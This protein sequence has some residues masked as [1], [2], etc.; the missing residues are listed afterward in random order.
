MA[1]VGPARFHVLLPETVEAEASALAARLRE[2][3]SEAVTGQLREELEIRAVAASPARGG[4][5]GRGAAPR[6]ALP[7]RV[8]RV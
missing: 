5:L 6:V 7:R 4:T 3:C 1:R 2:A 8:A